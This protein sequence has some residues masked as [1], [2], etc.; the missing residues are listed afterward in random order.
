MVE[1]QIFHHNR[2]PHHQLYSHGGLLS[3]QVQAATSGSG[4]FR[5]VTPRL[6]T[7]EDEPSYGGRGG[8]R[9]KSSSGGGMSDY[10]AGVEPGQSE[11]DNVA[12]RPRH[13]ITRKKPLSA[14]DRLSSVYGGLTSP[15]MTNLSKS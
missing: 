1:A 5:L 14:A 6:T 10:F 3:P 11:L 7:P 4:T 15:S 2:L 12:P 13:A 9:A 8:V